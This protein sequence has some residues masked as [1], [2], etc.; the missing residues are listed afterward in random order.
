MLN[1][2][3]FNYV[4]VLLV[5][6]SVLLAAVY[7]TI[8]YGHR[9]TALLATYSAYLWASFLYCGFRCVFFFNSGEAFSFLNGDEV[10]QMI[11]FALYIRFAAVAL[12]LNPGKEKY[13]WLFTRI[14]PYVVFSYLCINTYLINNTT[15]D[16]AYLVAKVSIRFFL[17]FTGFIMLIAVVR[18]R[19]SVFYRYLAAGAISMILC[20]LISSV[21]NLL[22]AQESFTLGAISWLM[23]G[24]FLDVV[25]FSSAIG[26]R[27]RQDHDDR[28]RSL[29]AL[30]QKESELQQ[31]ELEKMKAI[32]ETRE[33]ERLR[34]A[35]DLH[36]DMGTTLSSIGIYGKV[37]S[38]YLH[39][40]KQKANEYLEKIQDNAKLLMENTTDLIWSLQT[41]YGEAESIF[42]RMQKTATEMLSSANITP[43]IS[44]APVTELPSLNI[45]AQKACWLIFKEAVTNVC[46]YSNA[47]NCYVNVSTSGGSLVMNIS[48]DGVG[49]ESPA[50][51][52]G[53]RNMKARAA[54]LEGFF[55][56]KT[57]PGEGTFITTS[58]PANKIANAQF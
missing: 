16:T 39:T 52:N 10:F 21:V 43:H 26:Y 30:L 27:I 1:G 5:A 18:K 54:E 46:K 49:F 36:D 35:R 15:S 7:H 37:V 41:N 31:K 22:S 23:F 34:I 32:Y 14:T 25:F 58:F 17:L 51:G 12:E 45:I 2:V 13:A 55:N 24:F 33:E 9:K 6:G 20:G 42:E 50:R 57:G 38:S 29:Q 3:N 11:A 53:L 56:I 47:E 28:E 8:L 4:I 40:D 19:H 48:D 44:I